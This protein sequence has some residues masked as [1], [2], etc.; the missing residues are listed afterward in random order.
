MPDYAALTAEAY[1]VL[2][3]L[4][5]RLVNAQATQPMEKGQ[6]WRNEA[7]TLAIKL[8]RHLT[9]MDSLAAGAMVKHSGGILLHIDHASVHVIARA[10][11]ETYLVWYYLY[12]SEDR[13]LSK[14]RY[15][16]WRLGGLMDRQKLHPITPESVE[17][18]NKEQLRAEQLKAQIATMPQFTAYSERQQ[19]KLLEGDWKVIMGTADLA[20]AAGFHGTYFRNVYSHLCGYSHASYISA[21]Q[22]GEAQSL[23]DQ[24]SLTG[25]MMSIGVVV[26]AHFACSYSRQFPPAQAVLDADPYGKLTAERFAIRADDLA[27]TYGAQT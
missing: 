21:L 19:R 6:E 17:V 25:A 15:L 24:A 18:I 14:F 4:M 16:T 23:E 2:L 27:E 8:F 12:G 1:P 9:S 20:T 26:L 7:Q 5:I 22:V 3:D 11:L 13:E 10:A